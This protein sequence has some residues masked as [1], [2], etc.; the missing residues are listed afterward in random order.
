[1]WFQHSEFF[2]FHLLLGDRV[3]HKDKSYV[4]PL[5]YEISGCERKVGKLNLRIRKV[6]LSLYLAPRNFKLFN[7]Y[8]LNGV[9]NASE[10]EYNTVMAEC[11]C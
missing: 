1:M 11:T 5:I 4:M 2:L 8:G 6:G 7:M 9:L 3:L 10:K